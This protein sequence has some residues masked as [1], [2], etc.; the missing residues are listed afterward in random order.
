MIGKI[1]RHP[2]SPAIALYGLFAASLLD[3]GYFVVFCLL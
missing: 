3:V 1:A 2:A